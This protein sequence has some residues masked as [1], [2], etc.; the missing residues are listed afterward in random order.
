MSLIT[1]TA[2]TFSPPSPSYH[3]FGLDEYMFDDIFDRNWELALLIHEQ[4]QAAS[5]ADGTL[6]RTRN[7][8]IEQ[9]LKTVRRELPNCQPSLQ[10]D[11]ASAV[12]FS[13]N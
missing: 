9:L 12:R 7:R 13:V 4:Y 10:K 6:F 2:V 1:V 11:H 8:R 5:G 3:R